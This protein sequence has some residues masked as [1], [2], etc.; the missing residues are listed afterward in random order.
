MDPTRTREPAVISS[1]Q[2]LLVTTLMELL[3]VK[4]EAFRDLGRALDV[5]QD[6]LQPLA[7]NKPLSG[8]AQ[9]ALAKMA[10][11]SLRQAADAFDQLAAMGESRDDLGRRRGGG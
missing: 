7:D 4:Q 9:R 10:L 2:E 11:M 5:A 3:D 8:P 1:G 6:A